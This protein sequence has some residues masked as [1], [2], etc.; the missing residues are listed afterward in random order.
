MKDWKA[1]VVTWVK[2][3]KKFKKPEEQHECFDLDEQAAIQWG[4]R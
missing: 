3:D 4:E 2:N 1:A